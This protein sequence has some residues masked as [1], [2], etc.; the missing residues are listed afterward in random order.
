MQTKT[1]G[2]FYDTH[3]MF[4]CCKYTRGNTKTSISIKRMTRSIDHSYL[5]TKNGTWPQITCQFL[6]YTSGGVH[7]EYLGMKP[8]EE[9]INVSCRICRDSKDL[10]TM[11]DKIV[12]HFTSGILEIPLRNNAAIIIS[13][14]TVRYSILPGFETGIFGEEQVNIA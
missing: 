9:N 8:G 5:L 12:N 13:W 3:L 1:K 6:V 11:G 7:G 14:L 2:I 10:K 4:Y